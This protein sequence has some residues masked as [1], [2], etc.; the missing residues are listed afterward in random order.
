MVARPGDHAV[1]RVERAYVEK[2]CYARRYGS[3]ATPELLATRA[4]ANR[5]Q[6]ADHRMGIRHQDTG[7]DGSPSHTRPPG[8]GRGGFITSAI[9]YVSR[10][11]PDATRYTSTEPGPQHKVS[12]QPKTTKPPA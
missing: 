9:A 4:A 7:E 6:V 10:S 11:E 5:V 1:H 2:A 3:M 12:A 8:F